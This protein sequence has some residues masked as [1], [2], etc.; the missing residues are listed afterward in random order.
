MVLYSK[1]IIVTYFITRHICLV[2]QCVSVIVAPDP[3][4]NDLSHVSRIWKMLL[5]QIPQVSLSLS[6][7]RS[8]SAVNVVSV[9]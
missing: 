1:V 4:V 6:I 3:F 9:I 8:V 5:G 2:S 7:T